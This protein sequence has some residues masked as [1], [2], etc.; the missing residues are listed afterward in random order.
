MFAAGKPQRL[1]P[2]V[3]FIALILA[4]GITCV[5]HFAAFGDRVFDIIVI[6][7]FHGALE[8]AEGNPVAAVM[9]KNIKEI[10][11]GNPG[12][13][14]IVSGGDN[15]QGSGLSNLLNGAPVMSFFASMGV[16]V[17]A[18]GN[19]EFDW[20]LDTVAGANISACPVVCSNLFYKGTKKL[21]FDPYKIF[22][23]DG[24]KI[25]VVGGV[26]EDLP[27]LV[28]AE[29][30][31][32]YDVGG[33][34]ENVGQAAQDARSK[35]ARIVVALIHAGD[36]HDGK[37]GPVFDVA[38]KLGGAG[39]VVD[40]VLGGHTHD[41]VT[42]AA[43]NG[44]PVAI[45][46]CYGK[47]FIDLK[48]TRHADGTLT[49]GTSYIACDT[50][51]TVFP[52][53]YRASSPVADQ[54]V[55]GIVNDAKIKAG[56]IAGRKLGTADIDLTV[57]QAD[58]PWGESLA[59]N[60]A[61]DVMK[62]KVNADF[63]FN[64]N[65]TFRADIPRG[66]IT[67]ETLYAFLPFDDTITTADLTGAQIKTLLEQAVGDGGKGIQVAGLIFAYNPGAPGGGRIVSI[68][69]T[70]GTPVDMADTVKTLRVAANSYMASGA[71]GFAL[72]KLVTSLDTHILF[73]DALIEQV[74]QSGRVTAH[75]QGRIKKVHEKGD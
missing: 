70:D 22:E 13:T 32:D 5:T 52:Y 18:L 71:D 42:A 26:T 8:D 24:E 56:S 11:N 61:C 53:G 16:E 37:T 36:N 20:G 67:V 9:A 1:L 74:Q 69:K 48:I 19:H 6:T 14:L 39:G 46:N 2:I 31:R 65:G 17:S 25:A 45:A 3:A 7:D 60:W 38:G 40:A 66:D 49:F 62:E 35:G 12:R 44:T 27:D 30:F 73:R 63:A 50:D 51:S 68:S 15:Y 55:A 58:T 33:L 29:N 64:S 57:G 21:V 72:Y 47:G 54:A 59:G 43:A 41:I 10:V 75:I 4:L 23:K 34:V 28:S